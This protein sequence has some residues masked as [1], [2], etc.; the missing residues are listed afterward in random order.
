MVI[1]QNLISLFLKCTEFTHY[2]NAFD[3]GFQ[4][5]YDFQSKMLSEL[6]IFQ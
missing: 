2:I 1:V 4:N 3:I 6:N 5:C